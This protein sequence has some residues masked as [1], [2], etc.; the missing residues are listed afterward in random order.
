ME[1]PSKFL[2][3][4]A[5]IPWCLRSLMIFVVAG[6]RTSRFVKFIA[7]I[8]VIGA[9]TLSRFSF[10]KKPPKPDGNERRGE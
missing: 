2:K 4:T 8:V 1:R 6:P 5:I 3:P 9:R 10:A 7:N